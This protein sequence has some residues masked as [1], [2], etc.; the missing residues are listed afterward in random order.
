M[1]GRT[2][3]HPAALP[4][5]SG[6]PTEGGEKA[7][8]QVRPKGGDLLTRRRRNHALQKTTVSELNELVLQ[9]RRTASGR[10]SKKPR[11]RWFSRGVTS[12]VVNR[13]EMFMSR[14]KTGDE[15]LSEEKENQK[16]SLG[17]RMSS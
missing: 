11:D 12:S 1:P 8:L 2:A 6:S 9:G 13:S 14:S 4:S 15:A 5:E 10:A 17:R 7:T 3:A 16:D